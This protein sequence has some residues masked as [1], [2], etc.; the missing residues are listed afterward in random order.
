MVSPTKFFPARPA[1][2]PKI[3]AYELP[4]VENLRGCLKVGY[5][6]RD[7]WK[8]VSA[9]VKT[10]GLN[11]RIVVEQNAFYENGNAFTD[12]EI[13]RYLRAR[14]FPNPKGEWFKCSQKDVLAAIEAVRTG[15]LNLDAQR[16]ESFK[17]RPEQFEAVKR[18]ATYFQSFSK[19]P[20]NAKRVPHFLWNA[21]MRFGKTFTAYQLARAMKWKKILI[22]TFKPAV[23]S[24]WEEDLKT[25][26]D[27]SGW[28]FYSAK[29]GEEQP[30]L[31]TLSS[32]H[33]LVCF[34]SFQDLLGKN[35]AGGIKAKNEWI[36]QTNWDCVI[37][38]EYHYGAWREN[39]KDLFCGENGS[40]EEKFAR[41]DGLDYFDEQAMP[42]TTNH[43][44][45]LSGTPFRALTS[46]EFI[47]EQIFNWT[48]SDEQD[49][50]YKWK[51]KD[52]HN[53][54]AALPRMVLMTYQLPEKVQEIA[55]GGEF[56][57]F[58]LN[59]FFGATGTEDSAEFKHKSEVQKWLDLIRGSFEE[60]AVAD[61]KL[62]NK[63]PPMPFSHAPLLSVLN[64]T[65]WFLPN[66]AS[67]FAMRNLLQERQNKFYHDYEVIV[68]A[69][70]RA[71][72]GADA[73]PPVL[74]KMRAP[75]ESKT[76]T[77]SCMKLTT[78]VSVKPWTG[79][80]M[81]R[82]LSSPETYF[83]A[84]FRV[85][86]PWS[87][88]NFD[89]KSPNEE[90]ILKE[91]CYIFDFA[92]NRA[93]RQVSD[94]ACRLDPQGQNPEK[95]VAEF[96]KF[97]P[98]LAYDGSSMRQISAEGVLEIATSGTTATLLAKRW[99]SALLVNVDNSTLENLMKSEQ[100]MAA[101]EKIEAFR[102]LN[103]EISAIINKSE[104]I[105]KAKE[106]A[107]KK[108]LSENEKKEMTDAEKEA[109]SKRK[110]IQ[111]KLIKFATRIPIFMYLTDFRENCLQDVITHLES[112]LFKKVTGLDKEDF[113]L[114]VDLN[115]FNGP[116]MNDAVF[117]FRRYEDASLSYTG[118]NLHAGENVGGYNTVLRKEE[119][120]AIFYN[121]R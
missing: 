44:L 78:G 102:N 41:G 14:R 80:F 118:L 114:L 82:N 17:M 7:V 2:T 92:P 121:A 89:G 76:I 3:Y 39:A 26:V 36:H 19:D 103:T 85:Q 47:E 96:I 8:R 77:L 75:L 23:K 119:H 117:K 111:E 70:T 15:T 93:L 42:I 11:P 22:L 35:S 21:K 27:F 1:G 61:L 65:F 33:P 90:T 109:K 34:G 25:H 48:Y 38:D 63:R 110:M 79:I 9:Q 97:L 50:K 69:G 43:Y 54:Y 40:A 68:A 24:A 87:V 98:V 116:L 67:C 94:Y 74:K 32:E 45:Y 99:E 31:S 53:P 101:L 10:A 71:G 81:L 30:A 37:F 56:D 112:K 95:Q 100:A 107:N 29:S 58:D 51:K 86:T 12:H 59:E 115:V 64:H 57:E 46:G 60:T 120:E 49:A 108:T 16:T 5:T 113:K 6:E 4:G 72:I 66:V 106:K 55:R 105:K 91:E 104:A 28:Q 84:A 20:E 88:W 73:L 83:Q 18:T 13:H 62:G 52:G